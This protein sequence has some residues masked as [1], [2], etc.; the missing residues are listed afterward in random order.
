MNYLHEHKPEAIIH[1]D[2]EPSYVFSSSL[3]LHVIFN[4]NKFIFASKVVQIIGE[5]FW[6]I[7][8]YDRNILRDDSGHLKVADFGLSK[9]MKVAKTIKEDKPVS[10]QQ[11]SCKYP[12]DWDMFFFVWIFT[13]RIVFKLLIIWKRKGIIHTKSEILLLNPVALVASHGHYCWTDMSLRFPAD[14]I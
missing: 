10:W 6:S 13:F 12:V 11:T 4:L 9:L 14:M 8:N 3:F 1:R 7:K 2:L 5:N